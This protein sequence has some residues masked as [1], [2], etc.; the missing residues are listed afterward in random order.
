MLEP[1]RHLAELAGLDGH[2]AG[3]G[4]DVERPREHEEA[5]R[6]LGVDMKRAG[7]VSHH[8]IAKVGARDGDQ[9]LADPDGVGVDARRMSVRV[10]IV[11]AMRGGDEGC[12][13]APN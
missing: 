6:A 11:R 4:V 12:K 5:L 2:R 8:A 1:G 13:G 9:A 7:G 10:S 3:C